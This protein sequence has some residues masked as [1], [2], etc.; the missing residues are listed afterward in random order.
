MFDNIPIDIELL[1]WKFVFNDILQDFLNNC[2]RG[3]I[4]ISVNNKTIGC[5]CIYTRLNTF[6]MLE[7]HHPLRYYLFHNQKNIIF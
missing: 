3:T 5:I 2:Q 7:S 1:I 6:C 4:N